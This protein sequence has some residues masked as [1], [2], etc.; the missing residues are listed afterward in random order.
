MATIQEQVVKYLTDAHGMEEQSLRSLRSSI[1]SAEVPQLQQLFE[2]HAAETQRQQ[3]RLAERLEQ[4]G[5]SPSKL[6]DVGNA[7]VSVGKGLVDGVRSDNAGKNLRDAYIGESLEIVSY[8]L[9]VRVADRAGDSGT[10]ELAR[11][12]LAE[13]RATLSKLESLLDV[14]ADASLQT[15]GATA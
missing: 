9:L 6:K 15:E 3:Q 4:L 7:A 1:A 11:T 10:A 8:E 14:A 2:Q 12:L 5:A 13:E